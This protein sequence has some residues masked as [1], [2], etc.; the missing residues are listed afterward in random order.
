MTSDFAETYAVLRRLASRQLRGNAAT[1]DT[2][3]LVHEAWLKLESAQDFQSQ[4]H[5]LAVA[6]TAMRQIVVDQARRRGSQKRGGDVVKVAD[7]ISQVA[8]PEDTELVL[9]VDEALSKLAQRDGKLAQIVEWRFFAG[10]DE[11]EIAAAL[12][13][14]VRTVRRNFRKA[15]AFILGELS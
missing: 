2:T 12:E 6:A 13:C 10:L 8:M 15:R 14:D 11:A 5:Y 9:A 3:G 1:L 4:G 7:M